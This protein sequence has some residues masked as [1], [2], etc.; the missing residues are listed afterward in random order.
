MTRFGLVTCRPLP[1]VQSDDEHLARELR[2]RGCDVAALPWNGDQAAFAE[3]DVAVLRS[4]W[5]YHQQPQAFDLWLD[6]LCQQPCKV[7][8]DVD[9]M[10][11]NLHKRYLLDL[12]E[13]GAPVPS[14]RLVDAS[15]AAI[16]SAIR[17]LGVAMAVVK[18]AVGANGDGLTVVSA[19]DAAAI[20]RAAAVVAGPALV[21]PLLRDIETVGETS[22]V[23]FAGSFSH[24]V[25]KRPPSGSILVHEE[26]GGSVAA[27]QLAN[28]V[29]ATARSVVALLPT[30]PTYARID[31]V[32]A[33]ERSWL[34]EVE[35]VEPELFLRCH[36]RAAS[37]FADAL[38]AASAGR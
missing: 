5:D 22:L 21:Q 1:D 4:T 34:M 2:Q 28:D 27:T 37:R 12:A 7:I 23:F 20:E 36:D 35:V 30:V 15:A 16:A 29:V 13:R 10:R 14:T 25:V 17:E 33:A 24:A 9:L 11:W 38:L 8:N 3:I 31:M 19:G 32:L 6:G 26:R 18:P